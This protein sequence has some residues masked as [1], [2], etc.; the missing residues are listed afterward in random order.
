VYFEGLL[1]M[2]VGGTSDVSIEQRRYLLKSAGEKCGAV[3]IEGTQC[4]PVG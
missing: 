4:T 3:G 1:Y 2:T